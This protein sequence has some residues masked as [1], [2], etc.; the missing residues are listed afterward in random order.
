MP[1][2]HLYVF[3]G[4][5]SLQVFCPFL[6]Q[7]VCFC[8]IELYELFTY[9]VV[10]SFANIFSHSVGCLFILLMVSF[11]VQKFLSLIQ[12][13]EFKFKK[14]EIISSIFFDHNTMRLEINYR[15]KNV[16]NTNIWKVK[17]KNK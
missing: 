1:V 2:S 9:F 17:N 10:I 14:I 6:N 4:K 13:I 12:T 11:A 5:M 8:D 7:A 3:F 15:E 16:K